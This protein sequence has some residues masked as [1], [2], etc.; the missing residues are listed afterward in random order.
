MSDDALRMP[1]VSAT[2]F[3]SFDAARARRLCR[4]EPY[5]QRKHI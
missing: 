3:A 4:T 5:S 2:D 1:R